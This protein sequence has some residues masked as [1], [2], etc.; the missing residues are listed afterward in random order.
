[1]NLKTVI[2]ELWLNTEKD[3][4]KDKILT[5]EKLLQK[6]QFQY[7]DQIINLNW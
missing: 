5:M 7:L 4:S 2:M 6:T 3:A 1:M